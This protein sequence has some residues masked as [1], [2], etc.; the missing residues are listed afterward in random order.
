MSRDQIMTPEQHGTPS[1]Y[2]YHGCRCSNCVDAI[3]TYTREYRDRKR[4][5]PTP[6]HVHGTWNGYR[7][8]GCR[9]ERCRALMDEKNR[10]SREATAERRA[11]RKAEE[12]AY[13]ATLGIKPRRKPRQTSLVQML[14]DP[15]LQAEITRREQEAYIR[16]F[17]RAVERLRP[18]A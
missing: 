1:G 8:Y 11:T 17:D 2:N 15:R 14:A 4:S 10:V 3:R 16:G 9:C 5:E 12:A 13:E 6:D 7:T 18:T